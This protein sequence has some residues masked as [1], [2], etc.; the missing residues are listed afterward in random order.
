MGCTL[1]S[2]VLLAAFLQGALSFPFF[3]E[4]TANQF[5]RLKRQAYSQHF[6]EPNY[7]ENSWGT[8]LS[9]QTRGTWNS[10]RNTAQ[11]YIDLVSYHP[12]AVGNQVRDYINLLWESDFHDKEE[13]NKYN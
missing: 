8:A 13:A 6:W 11:Y 5:L 4:E 2:A 7:S 1:V 9:E 10:F 12:S 3:S